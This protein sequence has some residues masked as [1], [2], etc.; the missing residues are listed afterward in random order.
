LLNNAYYNWIK[1]KGDSGGRKIQ[2]NTSKYLEMAL[3]VETLAERIYF[4]LSELFPEAKSLFD[5]L[6][7]EESRHADI[8]TINMGFHNI[9]ALPPEFAVDMIPLIEET[10]A[11]ASTLEGRIEQKDITLPEALQL[12]IS[13]E[14]TGA[15]AYFQKVLRGESADTALNYVK[16]FYQ[17]SMHHAELIRRFKDSLES[18]R[19]EGRTIIEESV[20]KLNCWEFKS[21]GRQP[22]GIRE[23]DL[24]GCPVTREKRLDGVHDGVTAG[25]ACWVVAGTS[26]KGE[27]QGT[28][29]R[30]FKKCETCDFYMKV[31]D[32]ECSTFRSLAELL[33]II[34]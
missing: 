33:S 21:C 27:L 15:E 22:G 5:R 34:N 30:E 20:S 18:N 29:A 9:D 8:I 25:R 32:E 10:L 3:H 26:C 24:G 17:D 23:H 16:R 7:C 13:M 6:T 11:I 28:F 12:A 19:V 31:H 14:E 1:G 4:E 2:M